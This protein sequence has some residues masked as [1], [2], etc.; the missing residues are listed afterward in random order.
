MIISIKNI[1]KSYANINALLN[2]SIDFNEGDIVGLI[3]ENGAGKTTLLKII[4]CLLRQSAGKVFIDKLDTEHDEYNIK[5]KIGYLAENNPLYEE[6]KVKEYLIFT[7]KLYGLKNFK[8]QINEYQKLTEISDLSFRKIS[9][10]SKGQKQRVGLCSCL[11][12]EPKILILDEPTTGLDP[13]QLIHFRDLIK[14]I[15][16]NKIIIFST[17]I[18]NEVSK[19][20][21]R[22]VILKKGIVK[23]DIS[24]N[25]TDNI[26]KIF[27]STIES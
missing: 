22:I 5:S 27:E 1:S 6:M 11:L 12:H 16:K 23:K 13:K 15:S 19:V 3:G 25:E 8:K 4:S 24:I 17:H 2:V 26:E 7:S 21:N 18:I 20:C 9:E 14:K 10:L